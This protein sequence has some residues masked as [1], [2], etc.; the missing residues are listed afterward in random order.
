MWNS[1][2]HKKTLTGCGC[3]SHQKCFSKGIHFF[4]IVCSTIRN[5][6]SCCLC[7]FAFPFFIFSMCNKISLMFTNYSFFVKK[8]RPSRR[9]VSTKERGGVVC[10]GCTGA[11]VSHSRRWGGPNLGRLRLCLMILISLQIRGPLIP[12]LWNESLYGIP[13]VCAIRKLLTFLP[14]DLSLLRKTRTPN[15]TREN[16]HTLRY[17]PTDQSCDWL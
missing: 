3:L 10:W 5:W 6:Q 13:K 12:S 4:A 17:Y 8:K 15:D 2:R 14:M 7:H 9:V 1:I 11:G 16:V